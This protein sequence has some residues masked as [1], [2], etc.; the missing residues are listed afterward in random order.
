M[1]G[2]DSHFLRYLPIVCNGRV[3]FWDGFFLVCKSYRSAFL[4]LAT[5]VIVRCL[6]FGSKDRRLARELLHELSGEFALGPIEGFIG[7]RPRDSR[8]RIYGIVYGPG[9]KYFLKIGKEISGEAISADQ[10]EALKKSNFDP[11]LPIYQYYAQPPFEKLNLYLYSDPKYYRKTR[12]SEKEAEIFSISL[13]RG[14]Q[15]REISLRVHLSKERIEKGIEEIFNRP[16]VRSRIESLG[17][18]PIR[19]GC[20]HGD[21]MSPNILKSVSNNDFVVLD[22]ESYQT[23]APLIIDQLGS[24]DWGLIRNMAA[25]AWNGLRSNIFDPGLNYDIIK[26]LI[27]IFVAAARGFSPASVWLDQVSKEPSIL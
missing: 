26:Y 21:L 17:D 8:G 24:M 18:F 23:M 3:S 6:R 12:L 10:I 25:E 15:I 11:R 27:F 5:W 20:V 16:S 4:F 1:K 22:W 14:V 7:Y 9:C 19:K 2:S 13:N